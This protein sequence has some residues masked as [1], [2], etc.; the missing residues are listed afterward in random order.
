[1]LEDEWTLVDH[2]STWLDEQGAGELRPAAG[3]KQYVN[4]CPMGSTDDAN[5]MMLL[6][7]MVLA[8]DPAFR[9]VLQQYAQDEALLASDFAAAFQKLTELGCAHVLHAPVA[10]R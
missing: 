8:W 6:S 7:D 5:Q 9:T 3:R 10:A 4:K 2:T 1:M